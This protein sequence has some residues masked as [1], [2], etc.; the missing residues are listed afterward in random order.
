MTDKL[1]IGGIEIKPGT[2]QVV[3]LKVTQ[4]LDGGDIA[5]WVHVVCG[6]KPGP[7]LGLTGLLHGDEWSVLDIMRRLV[8]ECDPSQMS[9]NLLAVPVCN[10]I[11]LGNVQRITQPESDGPDLNRVFPGVHTWISESIAKVVSNEVVKH[12]DAL[13]DFHPG[14]WGAAFAAVV[15]GSDFPDPGVTKKCRE[16]AIAFGYSCVGTIKSMGVFPGPRS[17]TSYASAVLGIPSAVAE[18]GGVGFSIEE[19]RGWVDENVRGVKNVMRWMGIVHEP[20]T[21]PGRILLYSRTN[22]VNP[23]IGGLLVPEHDP[24]E[25][26]R[27]VTKGELLG[28]VVSPYTF[29]ELERLESPADGFLFYLARTYPVRPG[30]WGFGVLDVKDTEWIDPA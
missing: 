11:A 1:V 14:P 15:T 29:E 17:I 30:I 8:T 16:M 25:L 4:D 19:E 23:T 9:G 22:R 6:A 7:T 12:C 5:V 10:P 2:K 13:L 24:D 3:K 27:K 20:V 21:K 18:I 28:R 26:L